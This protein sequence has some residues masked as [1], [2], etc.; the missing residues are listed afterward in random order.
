MVQ[1]RTEK[2]IEHFQRRRNRV[3]CRKCQATWRCTAGKVQ[4][5][6]LR[7]MNQLRQIDA[8]QETTKQLDDRNV[9]SWIAK[10]YL[11]Q[12]RKNCLLLAPR[13]SLSMPVAAV[14]AVHRNTVLGLSM[15]SYDVFI[16]DTPSTKLH[17]LCW[18][19]ICVS[20]KWLCSPQIRRSVLVESHS[21]RKNLMGAGVLWIKNST[22]AKETTWNDSHCIAK[23][24]LKQASCCICRVMWAPWWLETVES[25]WITQ[26]K[27]TRQVSSD[28]SFIVFSTT[29]FKQQTIMEVEQAQPLSLRST[30]K[31]T[32]D[33][34]VLSGCQLP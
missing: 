11:Q 7:R 13:F 33:S 10:I 22:W 15:R 17:N 2:W 28:K 4:P 23:D 32:S 16:G 30:I 5:D 24:P 18:R 27:H 8:L 31:N 26:P 3:P 1:E 20:K 12:A 9:D 19:G 29:Y 14:R 6:F 21:W 34:A 25:N